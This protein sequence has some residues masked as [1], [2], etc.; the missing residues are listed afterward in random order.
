MSKSKALKCKTPGCNK[1]HHAHGFCQHCYDNLRKRKSAVSKRAG[2]AKDLLEPKSTDGRRRPEDAALLGS[3][4]MPGS[5]E[6]GQ[7]PPGGAEA[8]KSSR[9]LMIKARHE[10]MKREIDQIREDLEAEEED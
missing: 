1:P 7:A 9:L 10:A 3:G 8:Q 2:K 4:Q 6:N 5:P